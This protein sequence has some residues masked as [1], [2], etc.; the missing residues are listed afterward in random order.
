MNRLQRANIKGKNNSSKSSSSLLGKNKYAT[1]S[2]CPFQT[3]IDKDDLRGGEIFISHLSQKIYVSTP[4]DVWLQHD[5]LAHS[6]AE[7]IDSSATMSTTD[8]P[9]SS[10]GSSTGIGY[11]RKFSS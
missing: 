10:K 11:Y 1:L 6:D 3:V 7:S 4:I 9:D 5:M 8:H 2:R